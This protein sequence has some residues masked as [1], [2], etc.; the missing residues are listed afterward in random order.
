MLNIKTSPVSEYNSV[1][2]QTYTSDIV[3]D[4]NCIWVILYKLIHNILVSH[5]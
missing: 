2:K 4:F 3:L 5:F 1:I